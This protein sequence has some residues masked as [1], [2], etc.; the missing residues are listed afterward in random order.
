MEEQ[1]G[2]DLTEGKGVLS[3]TTVTTRRSCTHLAAYRATGCGWEFTAILRYCTYE[4][5][6]DVDM[7]LGP[8]QA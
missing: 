8:M 5:F 6:M 1:E 4:M 2:E 7:C 3:G